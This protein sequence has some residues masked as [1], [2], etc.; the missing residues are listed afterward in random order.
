MLPAYDWKN[1]RAFSLP[2]DQYGWIRINLRGRESE[3]IVPPD[4]YEKLCLELIEMLS[5]LTSETGELLV[6][7]ITRTATDAESA[8]VN[9]LPDL[10]VHWRDAAFVS[11]LKIKESKVPALMVGKKSTGQHA[12]SGFC[13]YRG[14]EDAG[15][16]GV[17][18]AKDLWRLIAA[19]LVDGSLI[20]A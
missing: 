2:T 5:I 11:S 7:D 12:S 15:L 20:K 18:A 3:G 14:Q 1:T 16:D 17:V 10:V 9:P 13:I 4:K 19:G 6:E 8:L